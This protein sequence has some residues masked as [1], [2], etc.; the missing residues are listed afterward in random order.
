LK[1]VLKERGYRVGPGSAEVWVAREEEWVLD[2]RDG[3]VRL[4]DWP[5]QE[6]SACAFEEDGAAERVVHEGIANRSPAPKVFASIAGEGGETASC[7]MAVMVD[8]CAGLFSMRTGAAH[9]RR[10]LARRVV[11]GLVRWAVENGA[12]LMYLQVAAANEAAKG[13][14]RGAGFGCAYSYEYWVR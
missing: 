4:A 5:D 3:D 13:L 11:A 2:E 1:E 9:R 10:G 8:G 6:W 7:G 12:G 14:Y